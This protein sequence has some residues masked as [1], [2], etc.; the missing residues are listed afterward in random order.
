MKHRILYADQLWR[1]Q[2][3]FILLLMGLGVAMTIVVYVQFRRFDSNTWI[4]LLYVPSALLLAGGFQ[5][6]RWRSYVEPRDDGLK[7]SNLLST[8]LIDYEQI[9]GVRVQPLKVA[10]QDRRKR[11]IAP[12]MKPLLESPALFVRL[13]GDETE[14]A[15]IRRRLGTRLVFDGTLALP[16]KD[17]DAAAWEVS[18]RLP[19]H[20]GQNM[21]GGRRRKRRR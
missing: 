4:W 13:R 11:M 5:Y 19:E 1:Q 16:V 7:V 15:A 9:R 10:F 21:G 17:P 3:F 18:S 14:L 6:Y 20:V 8:V 12:M 2:R